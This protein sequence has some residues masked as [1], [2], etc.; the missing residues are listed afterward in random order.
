MPD[1]S[2]PLSG[3]TA[4]QTALSAISNNLANMNTTGYKDNVSFQDLFYQ[5]VGSTGSGDPEQVGA[6]VAIGSIS[7]NFT[8]GDIQ[9][10]GINSDV[11]I[12]NNGFF[13]LKG[14]RRTEPLYPRW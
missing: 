7:T 1:F 4:S 10:T 14:S 13:I 2:I 11:A 9:T 6:G 12:S 8:G 3:L 5:N